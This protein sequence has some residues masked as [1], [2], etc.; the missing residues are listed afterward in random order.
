M[1]TSEYWPTDAEQTEWVDSA[2]MT[3]EIANLSEWDKKDV[4]VMRLDSL[5]DG[6]YPAI[7]LHNLA[8]TAEALGYDIKLEYGSLVLIRPQSIKELK[9]KVIT[10]YR[11]NT[12]ET[13]RKA[14]EQE[15]TDNGS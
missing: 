15:K 14:A 13:R 8:D 11:T 10:R 12:Y 5:E 7:A 4:E 2:D 9:A 3:A 1:N 6:T